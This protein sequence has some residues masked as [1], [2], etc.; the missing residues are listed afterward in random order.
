[1]MKIPHGSQQGR[2]QNLYYNFTIVQRA[3]YLK[4]VRSHSDIMLENNNNNKTEEQARQD[5]FYMTDNAGRRSVNY[6]DGFAEDVASFPLVTYIENQMI[7]AEVEARSGENRQGVIDAL[8]SSR[9]YLDMKFESNTENYQDLT[10][11]DFQSGGIY[12]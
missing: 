8:N 3:G 12:A 1:D 2:N 9:D 7:I 11:N 10:L 6:V 4:A 5:Y